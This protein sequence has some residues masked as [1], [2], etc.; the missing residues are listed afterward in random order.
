MAVEARGLFRLQVVY[1]CV[2]ILVS[3]ALKEVLRLAVALEADGVPVGRDQLQFLWGI[4]EVMHADIVQ[5]AEQAV[6]LRFG[7][8]QGVTGPGIH[9]HLP[10]P[11]ESVE[12][13][14]VSEVKRIE[15]GFRTIG[16]EPTPRYQPVMRESLMLTGD[17][18]IVSVELIVQYRIRDIEEYLFSVADQV[19][20]VRSAAEAL[21]DLFN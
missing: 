17:E 1:Q 8:S 4:P 13:E 15:I 21:E 5:P 16:V 6:V 12:I 14:K 7:K 10:A 9:Y 18:N 20:C 11:I 19:Q 3:G 2:R